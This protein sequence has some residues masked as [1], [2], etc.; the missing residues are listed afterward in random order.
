MFFIPIGRGD[1]ALE[2]LHR[3]M[4]IAFVRKIGAR[5]GDD[6]R[7]VGYL[8]VAKTVVERRQELAQSQIA[9][10]AEDDAV[11]LGNG[12]DLRHDDLSSWRCAGPERRMRVVR[13][14]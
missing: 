11:E 8:T 14:A 10:R 9:G 1:M 13:S 7:S 6:A 2:R 3:S 5:G 12:N 4:A